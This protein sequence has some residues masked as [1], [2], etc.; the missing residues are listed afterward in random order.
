MNKN[1]LLAIVLS[2]AVLFTY[3]TLFVAPKRA[4]ALRKSKIVAVKEDTIKE[5]VSVG[6][7]AENTLKTTKS[8]FEEMVWENKTTAKSEELTNVGGAIHKVTIGTHHAMPLANIL[9]IK[10]YENADFKLVSRT[11]EKTVLAYSDQDVR[12]T[13][14]FQNIDAHATTVRMEISNLKSISILKEY[15][16]TLIGIDTELLD[17]SNKRETMLDE[18]SVYADKKIS[19]KGSAF[20]FNSKEDKFQSGEVH[21]A[22]FRD[23]YSAFVVRPEFQTKSFEIKSVTEKSLNISVRAQEGNIPAKGSNVYEFTVF[24]GPQDISLMKKYGKELEKAVAFFNLAVFNVVALAIHHTIPVLHNIFKSW[25]ISIILI[26]IIIYGI[27]Y[28]LTAKSMMSMRKMQLIQPKIKA[29]QERYKTDPQKLNA[30]IMDVYKREKIN[31]LGGCLPFLLQMPIFIAL[32]NVLWRSYYFQ[33]QSFLWI[34]DLALPDR[35]FILPFQLPFLGNEFN[36]LPILMAGVMFAQQKISAK[37]TVVTDEQ[38]AMQQKMMLYIMPVFMGFIFYKFA[39][40][41]SLYFTVF[42]LLSTITQWKMSKAK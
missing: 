9:A 38:A 11:Q 28:P 2:V 17:S 19:R 1:T 18:Y 24:A 21:W 6:F 3:E 32:Y 4:E 34:K 27:T 20:K 31:P 5:A 12:I 29:L 26:S 7:T 36:I 33:G 40:G 30:E 42:Y 22:A 13:K 10:G 35:L 14:T 8:N 15:E 41:L 23:H 37:N 25:G 16:F 39:A